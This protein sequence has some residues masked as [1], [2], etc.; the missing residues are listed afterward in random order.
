[1]MLL[2]SSQ[3]GMQ[4]ASKKWETLRGKGPGYFADL[5]QFSRHQ[6]LNFCLE[7]GDQEKP[8]RTGRELQKARGHNRGGEKK[9]RVGRERNSRPGL[10][11]SVHTLFDARLDHRALAQKAKPGEGP[12]LPSFLSSLG[13]Q[14]LVCEG[15][16]C[17]QSLEDRQGSR[18]GQEFL[19]TSQV[20][21][22]SSKDPGL[23]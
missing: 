4:W 23:I 19:G 18:C 22:S 9:K 14:P 10:F 6:K 1:M 17:K 20:A 12:W 13:S 3:M 11:P 2:P 21:A 5:G 7:R 16:N 15:L 8:N